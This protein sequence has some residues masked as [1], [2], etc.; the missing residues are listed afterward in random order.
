MKICERFYYSLKLHFRALIL[1]F[2]TES[3][4]KPIVFTMKRAI[5]SLLAIPLMLSASAQTYKDAGASVDARVE[6][7]LS[8]MTLEE[9]VQQLTMHGLGAFPHIGEVV[10]VCDSPFEGLELIANQS[11]EAK[12]HAKEK[13][14]LG[15]P[16][17]QIAECL[18][19]LLAYGATIYPQAI[20]QGSTWNPELIERM[21][22]QIAEEASSVG[23]D[24]ALSPLFDLIRD[25]RYGRN[26]ECYAEDPYLVAEIGK[27]FVT[28]MQGKP[29]QTR[30]GIPEGKLMCTAKHFA[31]YS[32][33]AAGINLAPAS[34]G[35][36]EMRTLHLYP[37][38]KVVKE[39]NV[40]S[41]M[42][43]YNETDGI[44]AHANH[45]LLTEILRHEW[46]FEGYVFSD[47]GGASHLTHFHKTAP[48]K[49][50]AAYQ[51]FTAGLDL[52]AARPDIYPHIAELVKEGRLSEADVDVAVRRIL[53]AKFRSGVF[54]KKY[55]DVKNIKK[56]V[57]T[58][59]HIALAKTIADE[60]IV[61]LQNK[62]NILPLDPAKIKSIA[63]V[64]PNANQVQYGDYSYTR[65]NKSGLT[66]LQGIT[67]LVGDKVKVNY[68]KGC[69]ISSLD[70]TGIA[71]A[72][73]AARE[74]DVVVAVLGETSV[75][76][77]GL[78][79]GRGPGDI[80]ADDA[81]TTGEGY[82]ITDI[83]P[84]G[85]QRE[86]LQA[87]KATGKP[88]VLVLVHGRPWSIG[89]EKDNMDA[90]LEAWYPG[91]QGGNSVA[92]IIF[93]K[94]NPSGRLNATFP[95]SA[96]HIPVAYDYKPSAK[97][98]N[99][100][101][102]T[103]AKPGRDY[104]FSSP[105]PVF[106]FGHGLSYTDFEYGD[107]Q[108]SGDTFGNDGITVSVNVKNT[109][110]VSGKEVVQLYVNDKISSVTTP[111]KALKGFSKISLA[112]GE[113]RR[114]SFTVAPEDL[115]LWNRDMKY[116]TEP[117]EFDFI[118]GKSSEDIQCTRTARYTGE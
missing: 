75:I 80:E 22:A 64:G 94:V 35:K 85:V 84:I 46:G 76:L 115:G 104:V 92:D 4:L 88:I 66:V 11:K 60:S 50:E 39:A 99:R 68:A 55:A 53:K 47:Y 69:G 51:A 116:V 49:K 20:A 105:D 21:S 65:D 36:R 62:N 26:E 72:V 67:D 71:E 40:Y 9:K 52:E 3:R 43:S 118:F 37:F 29:E 87:L 38:E 59:E 83:N 56:H 113:S 77:S 79:W 30:T 34:L 97:G 100:E 15:I 61:L 54:D 14:R 98:I 28:G 111:V 63:V 45:H 24:Q 101:P 95:Q 44:P 5:I 110:S 90:I 10:G 41:V 89:W 107:M 42:P 23:V 81:F 48:D 96:G 109:G 8:R 86:L 12:K 93:G 31:G 73:E 7:L 91:E 117:G 70:T 16:P 74:S 6:D 17:I 106:P 19:G 25:P 78:G 114:V 2:A 103:L 57:H 27:A 13:T 102:G 18:H 82:D 1:N 112:P 32:V 108:I 33:P 58:P